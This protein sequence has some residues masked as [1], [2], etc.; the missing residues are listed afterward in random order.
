MRGESS[1]ISLAL[2][3]RIVFGATSST[4][5]VIGRRARRR[6]TEGTERVARFMTILQKW[7]NECPFRTGLELQS[8]FQEMDVRGRREFE[9]LRGGDVPSRG[10]Y[11]REGRMDVSG[12]TQMPS[13]D[14]H[15]GPRTMAV[16]LGFQ[17]EE[18]DEGPRLQPPETPVRARKMA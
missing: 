15:R 13:T 16:R 9:G 4:T 14:G 11:V 8:R 3:E 17:S 2:G 1:R 6:R 7:G 12:W 10:L 18:N 5:L